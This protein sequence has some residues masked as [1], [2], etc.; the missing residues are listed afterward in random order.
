MAR[1]SEYSANAQLKESSR[2]RSEPVTS[3]NKV[4]WS[5]VLPWAGAII[6]GVLVAPFIW[7]YLRYAGEWLWTVLS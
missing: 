1:Q 4:G 2:F 6:V 3:K 5:D 7:P